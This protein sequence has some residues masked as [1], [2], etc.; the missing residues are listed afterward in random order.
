MCVLSAATFVY[1]FSDV[2]QQKMSTN[3]IDCS[4]KDEKILLKNIK[5]ITNSGLDTIDS[6]SW[7]NI[8]ALLK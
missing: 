3:L 2:G 5:T 6:D 4:K 7:D 1:I 8:R